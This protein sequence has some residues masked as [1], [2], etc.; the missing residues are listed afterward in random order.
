MATYMIILRIVH[1]LAGILWAGWA[2]GLVAFIEP[3]SRAAGPEGGKFMQALVGKTRL[4]Q[5]MTVAPL[6]VILT[7]LLMYWPVSGGLSGRWIVSGPGVALTIGSLAG[8]VAYI[9]GLMINRPA[10]ERMAALSR[11]MQ[12]VAGSPSPN[13]IAELRARQKQLS[14]GG[15]YAAILL[16][17]S[18][19]GMSSAQ[20]LHL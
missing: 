14:K 16:V 7:G 12:S 8:I 10:A 5:A 20:Y 19:I 15:L 9:T 11:E 18:V 13:Q 17:I 2:F 4:V 3:A 1:I 6:L